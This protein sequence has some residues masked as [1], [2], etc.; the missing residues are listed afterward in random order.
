M[1]Y[2]FNEGNTT[3]EG[4]KWSDIAAISQITYDGCKDA[5]FYDGYTVAQG[6][7]SA[8]WSVVFKYDNC[9]SQPTTGW[10]DA[11]CASPA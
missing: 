5:P 2:V 11:P 8:G 3:L 10:F 9:A 6:T 4:I 1:Q 7:D